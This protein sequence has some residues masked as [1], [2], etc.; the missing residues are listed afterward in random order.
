VDTL[1]SLKMSLPC[2][3]AQRRIQLL[4]MRKGLLRK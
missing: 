2:P 3:D 4:Q 1:K